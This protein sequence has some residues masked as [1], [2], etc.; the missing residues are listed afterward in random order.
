MI[1]HHQE[2]TGIY[3]LERVDEGSAVLTPYFG[4]RCRHC[5]KNAR[6][7][8]WLPQQMSEENL[9]A[10]VDYLR[11]DSRITQALITGGDPMAKPHQLL[12]LLE[13]LAS[14]PHLNSIRIA[15]R[16][17]LLQPERINTALVERIASYN[18]VD[19]THPLRSR[20]VSLDVSLNH[21]SE[22]QPDVIRVLNSFTRRGIN[23]RG[24]AVLLKGVN[25]DI[26][27]LKSL[28]DHFL[29]LNITPYHLL[30]CTDAPGC[31]PLRTTVQKGHSLMTQLRA[32]S[33]T[34]ALPYGYVT[35]V[36]THYIA[37][38]QVLQYK[39]IHGQ[40]FVCARSHRLAERYKALSGHSCL[41]PLHETDTEGYIVSHYPD[42]SDA[43]LAY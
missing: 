12:R 19:H 17:A 21:A 36:G 11:S 20:N 9:N 6:A 38:D 24:H 32:L 23:V 42:G 34:Y 10:A 31:A 27:S 35:A 22:L 14:I 13:N 25:D 1:Q 16:H 41:P 26:H 43:F 15:T 29:A 37:P 5:I 18:H 4:C 39:D 3:G 30:H 2:N 8:H 28:I 40:R 7:K 33:G